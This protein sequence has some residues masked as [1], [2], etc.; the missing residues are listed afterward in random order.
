MD[1]AKTNNPDYSRILDFFTR[2][3]D[4]GLIQLI[5]ES[6]TYDGRILRVQGRDIVNFGNCSYVGLE[7]C[8]ALKQ[9]AIDAVTRYGIF[10]SSSRLCI[11]LDLNEKLEALLD[12]ITGYHTLVTQSTTLGSL[13]AI[14][15]I[16][17]PNDLI[18][19]DHQVHASVQNAV[20]IAQTQGSKVGIIRHNNMSALEDAIIKHRHSYGKIWYMADGMYSMLGDSCP[21]EDMYELMDRYPNFHCFVDDAHGMSWIGEHGKGHTLHRK[22]LHPQMVLVMSMAK[23]FGCCGGVLVFPT[24]E[25]RHLMRRLGSSLIYS[26]PIP[27]PVLGAC[28]ASANLHLTEE[29]T[30]R[31][32]ALHAR[33]EFFREKAFDYG[34]PLVNDSFSPIFYFGGGTEENAYHIAKKMLDAGFLAT[35]CNYP[36]V[37]KK[38]AGIRVSVTTHNTFEDIENLLSTMADVVNDL[39][40]EDKF[41]KEKVYKD[42]S[43]LA[44]A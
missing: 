7:T 29:I 10:L 5:N 9:G 25:T 31:Q 17:S 2:S 39:E 32:N 37:P 15:V 14:P 12:Q 8:E 21:I 40:R 24:A 41:N 13:S 44:A 26:G 38:N 19:L 11:G 4:L 28:I 42:F 35:I 3:C 20:K 23:G 16:T 27:T 30:I 1:I 33:I 36:V 6:D 34:L 43:A 18:V 22:A